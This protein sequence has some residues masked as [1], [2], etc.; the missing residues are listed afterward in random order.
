MKGQCPLCGSKSVTVEYEGPI[1][2]AGVGSVPVSGYRIVRCRHC[3]VSFLSPFPSRSADFYATDEY[4][5]EYDNSVDESELTRKYEWEQNDRVHAI[6]LEN[7]RGK[8]VAD[9][10]CGIGLFLDA[11]TGVARSTIAVEPM[12]RFKAILER[13]GHRYYAYPGQIKKESVDL[14]VCFD[15]L[16]HI[17]KPVEFLVSLKRSMKKGASLY[18]AV[19]NKNDILT[20]VC[21]EGALPFLSCTAHVFYY[22]LDSL[23]FAL[24]KSGFAI[25]QKSGMHKYDFFNLVSWLK[26]NKPCGRSRLDFVDAFFEANFKEQLIR[27]GIGSHIFIHAVKP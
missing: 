24:E 1:R 8:T 17:E 9:F 19:P 12:K 25:R 21:K 20:H 13:K 11:V 27:L 15:V 16:E 5:R 26:K 10:G 7:A 22:D 2:S 14:A 6:G 18:I 23:S 3:R 4:R